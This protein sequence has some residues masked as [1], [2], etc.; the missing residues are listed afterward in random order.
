MMQR[1]VSANKEQLDGYTR[2]F[3][4]LDEERNRSW[5]NQ[6]TSSFLSLCLKSRHTYGALYHSGESNSGEKLAALDS[7]GVDKPVSVIFGFQTGGKTTV[8]SV[9]LPKIENV[10]PYTT[11]IYLDRSFK[12]SDT[13]ML[14]CMPI[15]SPKVPEN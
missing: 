3:V 10:P 2:N 7:N 15:L 11:W 14:H 12:T 5:G 9:K 4:R 8:R 13:S 6:E 1:R